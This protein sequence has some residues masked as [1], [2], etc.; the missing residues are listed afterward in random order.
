MVSFSQGGGRGGER[1]R[2][3]EEEEEGYPAERNK[4]SIFS[5]AQG[6]ISLALISLL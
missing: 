6:R 2:E 5:L 3:G 4:F 1:K